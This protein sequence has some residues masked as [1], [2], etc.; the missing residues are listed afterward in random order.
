MPRGLAALRDET[1]FMTSAATAARVR[2]R[3]M[4]SLNTG[5]SP[6]FRPMSVAKMGFLVDRLNRDCAPLQVLRELTKVGIYLGAIAIISCELRQ[7]KS[8]GWLR[9][10][11][12]QALL[13][14][15]SLVQGF[16]GGF[17]ATMSI[18]IAGTTPPAG[19]SPRCFKMS[20]MSSCMVQPAMP[21]CRLLASCSVAKGWYS[22]WSR[23][24]PMQ[25]A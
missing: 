7:A 15:R 19:M 9:A 10:V 17:C 25:T 6:D 2:E 22:T 12:R 5:S 18:L 23:Q 14:F 8:L 20:S 21:V 11:S 24:V 1:L 16:I 4:T 13:N 3:K